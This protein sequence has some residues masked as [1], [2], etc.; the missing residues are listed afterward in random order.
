MNSG[1]FA[2]SSLDAYASTFDDSESIS[3]VTPP[4]LLAT[5]SASFSGEENVPG[6]LSTNFI[7]ANASTESA[8][9]LGSVS[10]YTSNFLTPEGS[11]FISAGS[12][13]V[14]TATMLDELTFSWKDGFDSSQPINVQFIQ[15]VVLP[16]NDPQNS[17]FVFDAGTSFQL[18]SS[19]RI[20]P[21]S[22]SVNPSFNQVNINQSHL[23]FTPGVRSDDFVVTVSHNAT[24]RLVASLHLSLGGFV[25]ANS[26]DPSNDIMSNEIGL[27]SFYRVTAIVPEGVCVESNSLHVYT[28]TEC[29]ADLNN[30]G[31]LDFFDV[32][33]FLTLFQAADLAVDFNNDGELNFFDVSAFLTAFQAGCP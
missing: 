28:P 8:Y 11:Q 2:Q 3:G 21:V 18:Q 17:G 31:L 15:E 9:G 24:T 13:S 29:I 7:N 22:G 1:A 20:T 12:T 33:Q 5:A 16:E 25:R 23:A 6:S 27:T 32:S 10:A 19:M 4:D 30:D 26:D 14:S